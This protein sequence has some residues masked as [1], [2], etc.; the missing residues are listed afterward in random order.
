MFTLLDVGFCCRRDEEA[1]FKG[2]ER[3]VIV[4]YLFIFMITKRMQRL[5]TC[6]LL[7]FFYLIFLFFWLR[8]LLFK[9]AL[10]TKNNQQCKEKVNEIFLIDVMI[11]F[12]KKYYVVYMYDAI[13]IW[14]RG[15]SRLKRIKCFFQFLKLL[16]G[17]LRGFICN[18]T[19]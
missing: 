16:L 14:G 13:C 12:W 9:R 19:I 17:P 18:G 10:N 7:Q 3:N 4:F 11:V 6:C 5:V 2:N 15:C 8:K 1:N